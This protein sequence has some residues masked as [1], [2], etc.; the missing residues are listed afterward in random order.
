[1]AVGTFQPLDYL[2]VGCMWGVFYHSRIGI[3]QAGQDL[4]KLAD[5]TTGDII[6]ALCIDPRRAVSQSAAMPRCADF[7]L[8][9]GPA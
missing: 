9:Q 2:G 4:R 6:S 5:D 3:E 8:K 1:M 7:C